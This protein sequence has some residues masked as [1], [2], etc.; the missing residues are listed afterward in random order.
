MGGRIDGWSGELMCGG[1]EGWRG[2]RGG[3]LRGG[4]LERS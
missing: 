4:G 3:G 1:V 2:W